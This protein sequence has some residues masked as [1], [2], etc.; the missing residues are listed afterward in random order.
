MKYFKDI[1]NVEER[2]QKTQD[3]L[4]NRLKDLLNKLGIKR[5]RLISMG[6]SIAAG[7]Q[8]LEQLNHYYLEMNL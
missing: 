1:E 2:I 7:I 6:N 5:L 4:N 3:Y 8:W